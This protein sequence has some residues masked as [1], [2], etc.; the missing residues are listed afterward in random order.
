MVKKTLTSLGNHKLQKKNEEINEL[1]ILELFLICNFQNFL[2][3]FTLRM[4]FLNLQIIVLQFV[5]DP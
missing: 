4:H 2:L 5:C 3:K 1:S